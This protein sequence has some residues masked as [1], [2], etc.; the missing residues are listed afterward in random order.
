MK[1]I[2]F[3]SLAFLTGCASAPAT[4]EQ[5]GVRE[6]G[7]APPTCERGHESSLSGGTVT[8]RPGETICLTIQAQGDL[9]VPTAIVDTA[10]PADTLILKFWQ[11]PGTT[12][13][14]L[15][16][17]NP[18]PTFFQ[19]K[20]YMLRPGTAGYEYTSSCPVL[21]KRLG[22]EHWPH[23]ISALRLSDFASLPDSDSMTCQ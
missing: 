20:A 8:I 3:L 16:V 4:F 7:K 5:I 21:S 15:T 9:V 6:A 2:A 10:N 14:V 12:D 19:Y 13:M 22:I 17:H 1:F 23:T 11:E 18:L